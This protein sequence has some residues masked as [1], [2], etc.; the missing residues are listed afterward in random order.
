MSVVRVKVCGI[1][2]LEDADVAVRLGAERRGLRPVAAEPSRRGRRRRRPHRPRPAAVRDARRRVR[3]S[4]AGRRGPH[5]SRGRARRRATAWRRGPAR[6]RRLPGARRSRPWRLAT[7]A[8]VDRAARLPSEVVPLVDAIDRDT[9][10]RHRAAGRL[11]ARRRGWPGGGRSSWRAGSRRRTSR[12]PSRRCGPGR[13]TS[14]RASSRRPASRTRIGSAGCSRRWQASRRRSRRR[15]CER[16]G[17]AG[18]RARVRPA[19]PGR[20]RVLRRVR[21]PLRSRDARRARRGADDAPISRR[22]RIRQ[23]RRRSTTCCATYVGRPTPLYEAGRAAGGARRSPVPEARGPGPHGRAQD[24]QR[25][26]PGAARAAHGQAAH[27]R[28][29]RR[30]PARRGDG[31]GLRA[32]RTRLRRLHGRGGHGAPGA[33]RLPHARARRDG[34]A[35]GR[36]QPHAQG[37]HQR[38]HA[39]LGGERRNDVLPARIGARP[40]SVPADGAR[41]P[42][43]HRPGGAARRCSTRP[44]RCPTWPWPASAAAATPWA[45]SMRSSDD[46]GVRLVGVEAGGRGIRPGEHAAR[47]AGG[48]PGVLHGTRSLVLQDAHGNILPTHSISAGL[49]YP[50]VGPEHAWLAARG[51]TEYALGGRRRRAR[52]LRVARPHRGH[53]AGARVGPRRGLDSRASCARLPDGTIV[54]V[55]LS[56]RGDKDVETVR[57]AAPQ[58]RR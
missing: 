45:S 40:A 2:R 37:R 47:F 19:G 43:G 15:S 10:R 21:R 53:P 3:R 20:A 23:F 50:S 27:R 48:G 52:R 31:H 35:G 5:R 1:T 26:R 41:V 34:R 39:R 58:D 54:L 38:G 16:Q 11:G 8:D 28:R 25:H 4:I 42:V 12:P 7:D 30:R 13:S 24:Q 22:A 14:R 6:L 56:G 51:R 33:Q 36:R 9:A 49:D 57:A 44:G 32:A 46:A 17:R 18:A 29:D 55:N